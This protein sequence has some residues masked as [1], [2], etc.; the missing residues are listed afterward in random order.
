MDVSAGDYP[1]E[2]SLRATRPGFSAEGPIP[3]YSQILPNLGVA[4]ASGILDTMLILI[5]DNL[6]RMRHS[7]T[8][9]FRLARPANAYLRAAPVSDVPEEH[10]F[11]AASCAHDVHSGFCSRRRFDPLPRMYPI[12]P[13]FLGSD[14]DLSAMDADV[15][16]TAIQLDRTVRSCQYSRAGPARLPLASPNLNTSPS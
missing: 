5:L 6:S 10:P 16:E 11:T 15:N 3:I 4:I 2:G 14:F 1:Y 8:T 13:N 7:V 12:D 9:V